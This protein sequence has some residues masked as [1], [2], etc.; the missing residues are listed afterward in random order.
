MYQQSRKILIF[1]VV[2]FLA[3]NIFIGMV[4]VMITMHTS[5]E[6]VILSG[7]HQCSF[8]I[9]EDVVLLN[10]MSWIF[11]TV[12][13]VLMLCLAVWVAVKHFRDLRQHSTG[14][15]VGDC[16]TVLIKTH[17]IYFVSFVADSALDLVVVFPT[18]SET[19]LEGRIYYGLLQI[20]TVMQTSVLGPRLILG[21]REFSAKLVADSDA[22]TDVTSIAFQVRVR[23]STGNGV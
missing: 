3:V 7:A 8:G 17:I 13:E 2:S 11:G 5:G 12:W 20:L 1:L 18:L 22:A 21:V 4:V 6:E 9:P 23:I 10:S 15:I 19:P 14:R 16:F